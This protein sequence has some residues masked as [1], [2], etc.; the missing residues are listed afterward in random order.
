M[1]LQESDMTWRLY[2]HYHQASLPFSLL[3][4]PRTPHNKLLLHINIRGHSLFP[5]SP[6]LEHMWITLSE[7]MPAHSYQPLGIAGSL[8]PG[9]CPIPPFMGRMTANQLVFQDLLLG[10][11]PNL[12]A[13]LPPFL[14]TVLTNPG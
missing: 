3:L 1:G 14:P 5:E 10:C 8:T 13:A 4:M 6:D 7:S 12:Q 11:T 2:H 9:D